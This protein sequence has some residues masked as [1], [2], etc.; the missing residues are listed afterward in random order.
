MAC[1]DKNC[2][3]CIVGDRRDLNF[4]LMRGAKYTAVCV[5]CGNPVDTTVGMAMH[6]HQLVYCGNHGGRRR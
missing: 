5:K 6:L 4:D 2:R 3:T 1:K